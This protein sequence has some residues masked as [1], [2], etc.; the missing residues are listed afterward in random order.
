MR[1]EDLVDEDRARPA[2]TSR[3]PFG[4]ADL[5]CGAGLAAMLAL[6]ASALR[7]SDLDRTRAAAFGLLT[8][9]L[10]AMQGLFWRLEARAARGSRRR[11]RAALALAL[12]AA[13]LA[14]LALLALASMAPEATAFDILACIIFAL[15]LRGCE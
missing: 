3:R 5:A 10:L 9:L 4:L 7:E 6:A 11:G 8:L 14:L 1:H 13:A 12:S 2:A 15:Y